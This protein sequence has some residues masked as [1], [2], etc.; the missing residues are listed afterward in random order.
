MWD[1]DHLAVTCADLDEGTAHVE[2]ALGLPL[3]PGG[4]HARYGTHNRLLGLG[5]GLYLEV[6]APDPAV[7]TPPHPRWFGLD[8]AAAPRLANWIARTTDLT[9]AL[10]HS[11]PDAG[12]PVPLTRGDL[13]WTIAVPP[14]GHLPQGGGWPTLIQWT[15]GQHPSARL[16]DSGLRLTRL[17]IHYPEA[18]TLAKALPMTD[19]RLAF[20]PA[21][22][23]AL[24]A[25]FATP[26]GERWLA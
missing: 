26:G 23:P 24:R 15:A 11:P 4:Q 22:T 9:S 6:I 13:A 2:A 19:P 21:A 1:L 25:A 10:T 18:A 5:P 17:E 20:L 3:L 7:P 16:P 14:D 12:D 8:R